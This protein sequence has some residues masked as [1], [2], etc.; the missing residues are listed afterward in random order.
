M[1]RL[2]KKVEYALIALIDLAQKEGGDPI[3]TKALATSYQ[4]PRELL[5]KIMQLLAKNEIVTSVQGV[6]GGY[7]LGSQPQH[8]SLKQVIE[9]LE[10]P[11]A[12]VSCSHKTPEECDCDIMP[13]C[14]IKSPLEMIQADLAHYF[15]QISL[16]DLLRKYAPSQSKP[17]QIRM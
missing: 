11:I 15:T 1:L 3:T 2:S 8:I 16:N 13:N 14:T 10:G 9:I 5:G 7:R 4:I 6:R 12:F 17:I